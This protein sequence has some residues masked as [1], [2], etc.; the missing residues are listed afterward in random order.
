MN[1]TLKFDDHERQYRE[2]SLSVLTLNLWGH[3]GKYETRSSLILESLSELNPDLAGFQECL[4]ANCTDR[5]SDDLSLRGYHLAFGE[6]IAVSDRAYGNLVASRWPI[7][8]QQVHALP[9]THNAEP[10]VALCVVVETPVGPQSFICTQLSWEPQ[11]ASVRQAQIIALREL[12]IREY[13]GY[14]L[15]PLVVGDFNACPES[16]EIGLLTRSKDPKSN[17]LFTDAWSVC[18]EGSGITMPT[19]PYL[20]RHDHYV[21][22]RIDYIFV[23]PSCGIGHIEPRVMSCRVVFNVAREGIFP[24]DHFGVLARL[25]VT[26][27]TSGAS[28]QTDETTKQ[29]TFLASAAAR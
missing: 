8:Y 26:S 10:R 18:G 24:S 9:S 6:A 5:I 28:L 12:V 3:K 2:L 29:T 21:E 7:L 27:G 20:G 15:A 4:R 17:S 1:S 13:S 19:G 22:R 25:R 23:G 16:D 14:L 11:H